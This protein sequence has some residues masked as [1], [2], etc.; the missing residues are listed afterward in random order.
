VLAFA[1]LST[2]PLAGAWAA[3]PIQP[4]DPI[5]DGDSVDCTLGFV[6]EGVG[7][8][9]G[10]LFLS[11][12]AHCVEGE[13]VV[14]STENAPDFGTVVYHGNPDEVARDIA[15]VEVDADLHERVDTQVRGHSGAP[16]GVA[17]DEATELGETVQTYGWGV[18]FRASD[19]TRGER[20][21]LLMDHNETRA[22]LLA[23]IS[24]GDS[25]GPWIVD[26]G[27]ALALTKG[28]QVTVGCCSSNSMSV[29]M[30]GPTVE[31]VIDTAAEAGISIQLGTV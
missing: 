28:T 16:I 21:G 22:Q 4:G 1:V 9:A 23:P 7:E 3:D 12:V 27:R 26:D 14:I 18:G 25:G 6:F 15:L 13:G 24:F 10:R 31:N 29:H 11:T 19:E 30:H 20:L 2:A 17:N 8:D 5:V